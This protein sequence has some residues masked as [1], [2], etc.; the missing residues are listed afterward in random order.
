MRRHDWPERLAEYVEAA[1]DVPFAWGAHDCCTLAARWVEIATGRPVLA[2]FRAQFGAWD[3]VRTGMR[4]LVQAGGLNAIVER[5]LGAPVHPAYAS[6]GDV[7]QVEIDARASLAVVVGDH[8][9]GAGP[10]GVAF[11]PRAHWRA[12]WVV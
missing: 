4:V 6:R 11:V 12:G 3:D 2:P 7:V 5:V 10:A 9:A 8:A 1:R